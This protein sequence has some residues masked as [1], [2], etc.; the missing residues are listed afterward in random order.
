LIVDDGR[1]IRLFHDAVGLRQVFYTDADHA[2]DLWCAS[3][4]GMIAERLKLGMDPS[5]SNFV[6]SF[7][8]RNREYWWPGDSCPYKEIRHLP[9]NHYLNLETGLRCRYWP[10]TTVS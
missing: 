1:H 5:A 6:N 10:N 8:Q 7:G 9:P 2:S 3:Q 4:P